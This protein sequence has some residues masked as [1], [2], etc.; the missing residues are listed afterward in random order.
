MPTV[1]RFARTQ[2][3]LRGFTFG[4]AHGA[5]YQSTAFSKN[6]PRTS[7]SLQKLQHYKGEA[8]RADFNFV[9]F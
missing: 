5:R 3:H 8:A 7:D 2:P 9:T 6:K 4:D 1:G